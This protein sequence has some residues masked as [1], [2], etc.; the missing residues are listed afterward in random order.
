VQS[1]LHRHQES[2]I[3]WLSSHPRIPPKISPSLATFQDLRSPPSSLKSLKTHAFADLKKLISSRLSHLNTGGTC[4]QVKGCLG[5]EALTLNSNS[6]SKRTACASVS[7][8]S[9]KLPSPTPT[10]RNRCCDPS[11]TRFRNSNAILA[12]SS[13]EPG[14]ESD[15]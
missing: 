2:R 7:P 9:R 12:K 4:L 3:R 15:V 6:Y 14:G 13:Q 10:N 11:L 5:C 8:G 1:H